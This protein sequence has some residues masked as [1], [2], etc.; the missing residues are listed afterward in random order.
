MFGV[1][2]MFEIKPQPGPQ[3]MFLSTPADIAVYGGAA[4][5]GKTYGLL[6]E[7]LR[8]IDNPLFGGVIFRRE[9]VQI[10]NEGGLWDTSI[11]LYPLVN[12]RPKMQP[13]LQWI[14]PKGD[15]LSFAHLNY[16]NDVLSW[17]GSQ[18]PFIGFDELT[19]FSKGQF[20]YMLSR[21]R[22][23]SGI[24]GYVRATTNP[25]PDSWVAEF[26]SWWIDQNTGDPIPERSGVI[27]YFIRIN[28]IL[29]WGDTREELWEKH[30]EDLETI[31]DIKSV[32][33]IS[34]SIYDN[35]ILLQKDPSYLA[36][37]KA[38]P[39]VERARLLGGNWKVRPAAGL[40]FKRSQI[41]VVRAI[42]ADVVQWVRY[43]DLAATKEPDTKTKKNED[44][45]FTSGVLLGKRAN[46]KYFIG[47]VI[48]LREIA[49]SVR[50]VVK[51]TAAADRAK[52]HDVK[53]IIPQDPGQAGKEQAE[54]Y[55]KMLTGF[56][57]F[58]ARETGSKVTRAEPLAA[59]WQVGNV[60]VLEA[61]WNEMYFSQLEQFPDGKHDDMVDGSSG[62]FNAIE[63]SKTASAF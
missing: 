52:Y 30:Q 33:F 58:I 53:I 49:S 26:I 13:K 20:F 38:L 57:V 29:Y 8:H 5:G 14:F 35:K 47:N 42:P 23:M 32:T 40:Y 18:I 28:D 31:N 60:E 46:G 16:E 3:E 36:N 45:D 62:A 19:H 22:S 12:A 11:G 51:N 10:T 9:Q 2:K 25:D 50:Q 61:E 1:K 4:G 43:W 24:K 7:P 17:Q 15:K 54:S 34:A 48:N 39:H 56:S 37:L 41:D 27:R 21:N 44:P 59:Q 63:N 55:V 6:L